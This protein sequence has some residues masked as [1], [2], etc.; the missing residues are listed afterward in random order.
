MKVK[1]IVVSVTN[2]DLD[3]QQIVGTKVG[4]PATDISHGL[5][6]CC[7]KN[8]STQFVHSWIEY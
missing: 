5:Q 4:I 7:K 6:Q 2:N 8:K 1:S 3:M